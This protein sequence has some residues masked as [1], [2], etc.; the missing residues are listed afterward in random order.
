MSPLDHARATAAARAMLLALLATHLL[1]ALTIVRPG[2]IFGR[3]PIARADYTLHF[4]RAASAAELLGQHHRIWGYNPQFM[5]GYPAGTVFDVNN[6]F[7]ELFV[8]IAHALGVHQATAFNL[9]VFAAILLPPVFVWLSARNYGLRPW[10]QAAATAM[11]TLLWFTDTQVARTWSIGVIASGVAMYALPFGHSCLYR[12]LRARSWPALAMFVAV[13][14]LASLLHP[15]SFLFFFGCVAVF[16]ITQ[17]RRFDRRVWFALAAFALAVLAVNLFWILPFLAHLHLKTDS[18]F[19]WVGNVQKLAADLFGTRDS[20]V[21]V[22]I[23]LLAAGGLLA[24]WREG[25]RQDAAFLL[26]PAVLLSAFGYLGGEVPV[27]IHL[28]TYRNNLVTSFLLI[29]PATVGGG[30]VIAWLAAREG[31]WMPALAAATLLLALHVTGRNL[32]WFLPYLRGDFG[33]YSL[34]PLG[35]HEMETVA[36]LREHAGDDARVMIEYWPLGALLPWYTGVQV[37]GGPYPLVWM[38]H[39][40][41][42]FAAHG[43]KITARNVQA[44]GRSIDDLTEATMET[45]LQTYNVGWIVAFTDKAKTRFDAM[46]RLGVAAD[47][48]R[49]RIYRSRWTPDFVL[50]GSGHVEAA[51]GRIRVTNASA[52][53]LVLKYHWS[54]RLVSEPPQPLAPQPV[55]DDPI[56]FIAVPDNRL[57]EFEIRDREL[58]E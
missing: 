45:Y 50:L 41:A 57:G 8:F 21:R 25:R 9:F 3:D 26:A 19:H 54:E 53:R 35:R 38:P 18:G 1:L 49:Y 23:Y 29:V 43:T 37:I 13:G 6:H 28:E 16:L 48:G 11:A 14:S 27:L 42:N 56:P 24:W 46:A 30:R 39:N 47:L 34:R 12:Y 58:L 15:L 44:F 40:F 22:S 20:G 32:E 51:C 4:S 52:G 2:V 31:P 33:A 7:I 36:W 10:E 55:L 5:A 17:A